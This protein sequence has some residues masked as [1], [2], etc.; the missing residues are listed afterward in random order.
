MYIMYIN[1]IYQP[2]L[3]NTAVTMTLTPVRWF[4]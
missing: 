2:T 3:Q 1:G 4:L